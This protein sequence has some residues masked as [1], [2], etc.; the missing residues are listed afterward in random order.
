MAQYLK[1]DCE[2]GYVE[3]SAEIAYLK[4]NNLR[5]SILGMQKRKRWKS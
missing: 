3:D 4:F 5:H 1:P 2:L